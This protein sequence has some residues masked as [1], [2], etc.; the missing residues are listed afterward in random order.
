MNPSYTLRQLSYFCALAEASS[1]RQAALTLHISESALTSALDS[2]ERA[3]KVQL[4][5]RRKALGISLTPGG[6]RLA[7]LGRELLRKATE[8]ENEAAGLQG[9]ISGPVRLGCPAGTAPTLLPRII[10]ACRDLYPDL[11][12][13]FELGQL[14]DLLPSLHA[15]L[16]DLII[17]AGPHIPAGLQTRFLYDSPVHVILPSGHPLA[18]HE[19]VDLHSLADQ[20][21]ILLDSSDSR[22][23]ALSMFDSIGLTPY[24]RMRSESFELVR[25]LVGRGLG[26]SLQMQRP[27]GDHTYEGLPLSIRTLTPAM[28]GETTRIGWPDYVRLS[29][30]ASA[31]MDLVVQV[32][33]ESLPK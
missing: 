1:I 30:R 29:P 31:L 26:Y 33:S 18:V 16:L 13:S 20:P 12:V 17:L 23:H 3:L 14:A 19:F 2:L 15:G 6:H 9:T 5:V 32:C 4:C 7:E 25:S 8:L 10:M 11:D 21:L 28:S 24:I 27:W 22:E